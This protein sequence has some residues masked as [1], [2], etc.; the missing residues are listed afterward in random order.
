MR[1][2]LAL[3]RKIHELVGRGQRSHHRAGEAQTDSER[4]VLF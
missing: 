2:L 3:P 1:R 4:Q